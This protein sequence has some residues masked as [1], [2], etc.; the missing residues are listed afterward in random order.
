MT[1]YVDGVAGTAV[2]TGAYAT[3]VEIAPMFMIR[4]EDTGAQDLEID[5]IK[6]VEQR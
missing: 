3:M 2:T 1:P 5:Y 6:V 4:N